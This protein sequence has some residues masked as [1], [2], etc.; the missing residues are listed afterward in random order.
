MKLPSRYLLFVCTVFLS[1]CSS[2]VEVKP[3]GNNVTDQWTEP[4]VELFHME[5]EEKK[6]YGVENLAFDGKGS[7]FVTDLGGR[8]YV[9]EPTANSFRGKVVGGRNVGESCF[10]IAVGT[11]G[12]IYVAVE[13]SDAD[14]GKLTRHIVKTTKKR[15]LDKN[16][17]PV[18][19]PLTDHIEGLNG[20][21]LVKKDGSEYLYLTSS[22]ENWV[23]PKGRILRVDI[24]A[25]DKFKKPV[26]L[27][28]DLGIVNG[29]SFSPDGS[30]L[31]FTDT[32]NGVWA[33]HLESGKKEQV[34]N[35]DGLLTFVDDLATSE[36]G[37]V[38][39]ALN[40]ES[41]IVPIKN[42]KVRKGYS[43][44]NL[45]APSSMKFGKGIG[46]K[47]KWLYVTELSTKGRS[48]TK[49]GRGIWVVPVKKLE[50]L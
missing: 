5:G 37:T 47:S 16:L 46:F 14:N 18:S 49:D 23:Y 33:F 40:S 2:G 25:K 31:Y 9:I 10:G 28:D 39:F 11:D 17:S 4:Y 30:V 8:I 43:I 13:I 45:G 1:S 34:Y 3:I 6:R 35:P 48:L 12:T 7:L 38:W 29:L 41:A 19:A 24:N 42:K 26:K 15:L 32:I 27:D 20:I 50:S 44:G 21:E 22:N 36:D